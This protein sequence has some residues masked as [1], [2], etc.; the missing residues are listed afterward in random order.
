L[1]GVS[2]A[3]KSRVLGGNP[4]RKAKEIIQLKEIS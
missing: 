4:R 2:K 3:E 1:I